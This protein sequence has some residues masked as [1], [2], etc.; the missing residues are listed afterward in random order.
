MVYQTQLGKLGFSSFVIRS[1]RKEQGGTVM[2]VVNYALC[3][4]LLT[5][6]ISFLVIAVIVALNKTLM[7]FAPSE[8]E[9]DKSCQ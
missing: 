6:L 1:Y 4:Y 5:A 8:S 2:N 3:A 9:E 7:R